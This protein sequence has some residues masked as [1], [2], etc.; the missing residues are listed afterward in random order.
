MVI[1]EASAA[2]PD[3]T[4]PIVS[5]GKGNLIFN[6]SVVADPGQSEFISRFYVKFTTGAV[7]IPLS[8]QTQHRNPGGQDNAGSLPSGQ[9]LIG[10]MGDY[11]QDGYLDGEL[12]PA[13]NTPF[14]L[15]V[16]RG[17][18]IAQRRPWTSD[19]PID[20]FG[21][22]AI[23]LNG[24]LQNYPEPIMMTVWEGDYLAAAGFLI[25]INSGVDA[26]LLNIRRVM[27]DQNT[28]HSVKKLAIK[29]S[30]VLRGARTVLLTLSEQLKDIAARKHYGHFLHGGK[31]ERRNFGENQGRHKLFGPVTQAFLA[32]KDYCSLCRIR[33][34]IAARKNKKYS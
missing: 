2:T 18:P 10:R 12:V 21:A 19:I 8:L 15:L 13:E 25:A 6:P 24:I 5:D 26:A 1:A 20:G 16:G 3:G 28:P 9:I 11:D 27:F 30:R 17:N 33:G 14:D 29:T 34:K 7:K 31:L 22:A 32:R 23:T 4:E